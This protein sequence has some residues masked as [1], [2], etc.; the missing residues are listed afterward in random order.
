[1]DVWL[2][3][4]S[5]LTGN[6]CGITPSQPLEI[7]YCRR[8]TGGWSYHGS[9]TLCYVFCSNAMYCSWLPIDKEGVYSWRWVLMGFELRSDEESRARLGIT[10]SS[11]SHGVS[12]GSYSES[13]WVTLKVS[14]I[15]SSRQEHRAENSWSATYP[16]ASSSW[17]TMVIRYQ[18]RLASSWLRSWEGGPVRNEQPLST[19]MRCT[20]KAW[21]WTVDLQRG[22]VKKHHSSA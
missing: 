9:M 3:L 14:I 7:C 12:Y 16:A 8:S 5:C 22:W 6:D 13:W 2:D 20:A 1:M 4:G 11:S 19:T 17:S 15:E 18:P 21:W 10:M